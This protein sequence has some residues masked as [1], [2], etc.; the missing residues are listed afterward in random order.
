MHLL[1]QTKGKVLANSQ[2]PSDEEARRQDQFIF[3][4]P[5]LV[6]DARGGA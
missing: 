4:Q 3:H 2:A 5:R 6:T 1:I